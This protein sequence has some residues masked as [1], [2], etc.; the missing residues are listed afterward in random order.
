MSMRSSDPLGTRSRAQEIS[1]QLRKLGV[2]LGSEGLAPPATGEEAPSASGGIECAVPGRVIDTPYGPCF[3]VETRFPRPH[4]HGHH[5]LA[6]VLRL[7]RP[8]SLLAQLARDERLSKQEFRTAI[9]FDIETS[10]MGIGA[11]VYAFMVG[12]GTF[13]GDEF[14]LRQYFLRDY[15]EE[16]AMLHLLDQQIQERSWWI[17]FN[18]RTFDLPILQAR[19]TCGRRRMPLAAAPHLDLLYPARQLWRKRLRSCALSSLEAGVLGAP[20]DAD[21]P[22]W[23]VPQLYFEY[24]RY[25][26]TSYM[27][28]VFYHN[29][30]DILSLVTLSAR[31][32]AVLRNAGCEAVE[33]ATDL[34][35]L[36]VVLGANDRPDLAQ[37]SLER[38]LLQGLPIE[39]ENEALHHL[40]RLLRRTGLTDRAL[41]VWQALRARGELSAYLELAKEYEHHRRDPVSALRVVTEAL[42]LQELPAKGACSA[43]EL[44]QRLERLRR[45]TGS[46]GSTMPHIESY[47]FGKIVVDGLEFTADVL[48][49]PGGVRPRWRRKEGH[50]LV[51]ED[52]SDV[53]VAKP[54]TLVIG[55]GNV[56]LM[57]VPQA[58]LDY[59]SAQ[60]LRVEAHPTA[61]AC[62]RY[63]ELVMQ[64]TVGAAL[65]LTC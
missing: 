14:C 26:D 50:L 57:Q 32:E 22:G 65:H 18:G 8:S 51:P 15:C 25:G 10:G 6:D 7:E 64:G 37:V 4:M 56:G 17:S 63:N 59:L 54:A 36:G 52:L 19:F 2:R 43:P 33:H 16:E 39:L 42:S 34:Y 40:G 53:L 61:A 21:V 46:G 31:S 41:A 12:F 28:R 60:G 48:I 11:G 30:Q 20:R 44:R 9:F 3:V 38:A 5:Q 55:T 35:S 1:E 47:S 58:T 45:K 24:L 49:L 27:P 29:A 23:L 13:E 62:Q